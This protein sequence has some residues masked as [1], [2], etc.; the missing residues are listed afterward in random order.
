MYN[1]QQDQALERQGRRP[2]RLQYKA[3]RARDFCPTSP[4]QGLQGTHRLKCMCRNN[5]RSLFASSQDRP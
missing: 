1:C 3:T 4:A 5:V 2:W